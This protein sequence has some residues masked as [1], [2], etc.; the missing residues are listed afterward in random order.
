MLA[1][2]ASGLSNDEI[3][4]KTGY[5]RAFIDRTVATYPVK[6]FTNRCV[7]RIRTELFKDKV[8]A[9]KKIVEDSLAALGEAL[10]ELRDPE[11][12]AKILCDAKSM[13]ALAGVVADMNGLL[14]LE[15]GQSTENVQQVSYSYQQIRVGLQEL[16]KMDPVFEYP[17][18]PEPDGRSES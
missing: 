10:A 14:R 17:K 18:L 7:E 13:K 2:K 6:K 11:I 16:A 12:R 5:K 3:E 15:L 9:L 1:L 4:G 8:P